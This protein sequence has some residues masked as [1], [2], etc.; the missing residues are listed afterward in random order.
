MTYWFDGYLIAAAVFALSLLIAIA[1]EVAAQRGGVRLRH[2]AH[3][4]GQ[5]VI[6]GILLLDAAFALSREGAFLSASHTSLSTPDGRD[7]HQHLGGG[8]QLLI[9]FCHRWIGFCHSWIS[10]FS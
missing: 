9:H 10:F 7:L 1:H 8:C 3:H 6:V 5:L 2:H 4:V